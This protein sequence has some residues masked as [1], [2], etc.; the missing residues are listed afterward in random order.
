MYCEIPM[1]ELL[2]TSFNLT[3]DDLIQARVSAQNSKGW[4]MVSPINSA[5]ATI[6]TVPDKV[7]LAPTRGSGTSS[8]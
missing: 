1:T 8:T 4:S 5:G 7:S 2:S 6:E 3:K